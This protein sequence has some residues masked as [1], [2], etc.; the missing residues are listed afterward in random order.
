MKKIFA[1]IS[2]TTMFLSV[3]TAC[4]EST[5]L[6]D[7][8]D[9]SKSGI[10]LDGYEFKIMQTGGILGQDA[11]MTDEDI[12]GFTA[13]TT[14]NDAIKKRISDI[15][16]EMNCKI[17]ISTVDY[18]SDDLFARFIGSNIGYDAMYS[19]SPGTTVESAYNGILLPVENYGS[20]IDYTNTEK[21]G[22]RNVVETNSVNGSIY[23]VSPIQWIYKQP[24]IMGLTVFNIDLVERYN[25]TNPKE[26]YENDMWTW[27]SFE[28]IISDYYVNE[29]DKEVF[30]LAA[31]SYDL[32][33]LAA[34]SNGVKY[35]D[36]SPDGAVFKTWESSKMT[37][38]LDWYSDLVK[39]YSDNFALNMTSDGVNWEDITE[40]FCSKQDS[41]AC[42]ASPDLLFYNIIYEVKQYSVL[43]FPS[44]PNG[45]YGEWA[46]I[47]EAAEAFSVF[48]SATDPEL[49]FSVI[50]K[51]CEPLDGFETEEDIISYLADNVLYSRE[52]AEIIMQIKDSAQYTYWT[53]GSCQMSSFFREAA[54]KCLKSTPTELVES[55]RNRIS[56]YLE[57]YALPNN[58]L[59]DLIPQ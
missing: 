17:T 59:Y 54:N 39:N 20:Y 13:T 32:T 12:F 52:D 11:E 21:Y 15:Q 27:D 22:N 25:K 57:E 47:M 19:T 58:T 31:R 46:A 6:M 7:F 53:H 8:I 43:P 34:L 35:A 50:D 23:G 9:D 4:G 55:Y 24:R 51:L 26:Y 30:S 56:S 45:V 29:N 1:L 18:T 10:D 42:L 36:I 3:L 33:K 40:H 5:A 41:M 49:T 28:K 38:A 14:E 16:N 37:E 48:I 44:G 2:A